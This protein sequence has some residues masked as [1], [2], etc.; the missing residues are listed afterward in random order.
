MTPELKESLLGV[1][2]KYV[3]RTIYTERFHIFEEALDRHVRRYETSINLAGLPV[4]LT[5]AKYEAGSSSFTGRLMAVLADD[6]EAV[7]LRDTQANRVI[8][9]E[10]SFHGISINLSEL[11]RSW[12]SKGK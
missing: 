5:R 11:I 2:A 3:D 4:D 9:L 6:L 1:V 12:R 7:V 8:K 10:P